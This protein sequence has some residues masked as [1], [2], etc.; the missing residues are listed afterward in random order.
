MIAVGDLKVHVLSDGGFALDG[1]AMFGVVP[2]VLWEKTHPPDERN[3]VRMA[4]N[5]V[6]IETQGRRVLVDSGVGDKL[7]AK[8]REIYGVD[9]AATVLGGLRGLGLGPEDVDVVVN[10][11]LHFDH[12]GGNTRLEG[13]RLVPTFP[14]ARY[15]IQLG[16]WEDASHPN[17]RTRA[18]YK[19]EDFVPLAEARQLETIQGEVEVAPGVRVKPV[20]GHTAYHQIVTVES[21]GQR[22]VIPSDILPSAGH[23]PL[24]FITGF[25]LFPLGTLHA[26]RQLLESAVQDGAWLVFY[27]D[28]RTPTGRVSLKKDRYLLSEVSQ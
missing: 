28:P 26:K 17:E 1:G 4:L 25:D 14:K 19:E 24:A 21:E 5:A 27:H 7:S 15:L 6:L 9:R 20:G 8:E 11:H 3:R 18:S 13:D 10:T 12:C 22:L 16:E 23:L 2:R